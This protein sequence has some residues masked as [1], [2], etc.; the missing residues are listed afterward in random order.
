MNLFVYCN[1]NFKKMDGKSI[2]TLMA[3]RKSFR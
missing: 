1:T 2:V 3:M